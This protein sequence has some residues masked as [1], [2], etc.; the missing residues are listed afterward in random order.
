MGDECATTCDSNLHTQIFRH[1]GAIY[2][3]SVG[4]DSSPDFLSQLLRYHHACS[5]THNFT[6][7]ICTCQS[8]ARSQSTLGTMEDLSYNSRHSLFLSVQRDLAAF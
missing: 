8:A 1:K 6:S 4:P 3:S 2:L 5:Q 7:A